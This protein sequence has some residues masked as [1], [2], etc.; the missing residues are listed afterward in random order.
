[1]K[2]II[3]L[4]AIFFVRFLDR[5]ESSFKRWLY[6]AALVLYVLQGVLLTLVGSIYVSY[7]ATTVP[8]P[9]EKIGKQNLH[10]AKLVIDLISL[11]I[12]NGFR[13]FIAEFFLS[14]I[15]DENLDILGGNSGITIE[16]SI[17]V[18]IHERRDDQVLDSGIQ[19]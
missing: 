13:Y 5:G 3:F 19:A 10:G 6:K 15:F 7:K 17:G 2:G 4:T 12:N 8:E 9:E 11:I 16:E 14:K 18:H 1:M